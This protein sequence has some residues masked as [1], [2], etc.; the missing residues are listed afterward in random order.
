MRQWK[1][2][3]QVVAKA[4]HMVRH[5]ARP[6][7]VGLSVRSDEQRQAQLGHLRQEPG[8]PERC[9]FGARR[10]VSTLLQVARESS[11]P[12]ARSDAMQLLAELGVVTG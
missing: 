2:R 3:G 1:N 4:H 9:A 6:Q 8:A 11:D 5:L 10:C 12:D 7:S